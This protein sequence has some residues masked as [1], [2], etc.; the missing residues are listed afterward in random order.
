M[1]DCLQVKSVKTFQYGVSNYWKNVVCALI[2]YF[3]ICLLV[4][5]TVN[6]YLYVYINTKSQ[7]ICYLLVL[8]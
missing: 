6:K 2:F 3:A 5:T 1:L 4:I 7:A 8:I